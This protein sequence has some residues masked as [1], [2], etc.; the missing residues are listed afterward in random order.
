MLKKILFVIYLLTTTAIQTTFAQT[1][2]QNRTVDWSVAGYEGLQKNTS[3]IV[4]V[5][6]FGAIGDGITV[7]NTALN[8]AI[9]SLSGS[10]GVIYFPAGNY[11]FNA[12]VAIPDSVTLRGA[13]A[14][15]TFIK[16]NT[17]GTGGSCFSVSGSGANTFTPLISG[18]T[19]GSKKVRVTDPSIF[20]VGDFADIRQ[21]NGS[22]DSNPISWADFSVG[23]VIR[24][25]KIDADTLFFKEALRI[26]YN[27]ALNPEIRKITPKREIG[28][29]CFNIERVDQ[30]SSPGYNFDFN[31]AYNCWIKNIESNK[32]VG[33]HVG[34][35]ICYHLSVTGSYI[36][37]A[38]IFDGTG[39]R[40]Y[41]VC[42]FTRNSL[43]LVE[44]NIFKTLRHSMMVKQGANGNVFAYNYSRDPKRSEPIPDYSA[45]ISL[46]G[47]YPFANLFEGNIVQNIMPDLYWGPSGPFNT[48]FRNR[49]EWY[50]F[51]MSSPSGSN[52]TTDY[53]NIV[54]LEIT[55]TSFLK[56]QYIVT[57]TNHFQHGVNH[58][59]TI[60]PTGTNI[61]PDITY[62]YTTGLPSFWNKPLAEYPPIGTQQPYNTYSNPAKDR[63]NSGTYTNCNCTLTLTPTQ[64]QT[65]VCENGAITY[66]IQAYNKAIYNWIITGNGNITTGQG[67]NTITVQ[68]GN[69]GTGTVTVEV[70]TP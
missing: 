67:T 47:H 45:D 51:V 52:P 43:C 20:T 18:Y 2:P 50:G 32:S 30:S 37:D 11:L 22:W 56:G 66:S 44:N 36:H 57:G 31:L 5:T 26:D 29:E 21:A 59:G 46:H 13:G 62:Y 49:A 39:T 23:Q 60:K 25:I 34:M 65:N 14:T 6:T 38:F 17:G 28:F 42:M 35:N 68:W 69:T 41:G 27:S 19:F 12:T 64:G 3:N 9:A 53:A 63:Y 8:T 33:T 55:N 1:I 7:T 58:Q 54:G 24:I 4:D 40:G 15:N 61:L 16:F 10:K 48:F 70:T